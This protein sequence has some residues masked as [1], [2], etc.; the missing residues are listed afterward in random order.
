LH[1]SSY[2]SHGELCSANCHID[3]RWT[4]KIANFGLRSLARSINDEENQRMSE[5]WA[6][7]Q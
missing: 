7:L 2:G 1:T 4:V 3:N 6:N 5:G